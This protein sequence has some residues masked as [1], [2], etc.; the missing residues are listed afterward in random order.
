M[1]RRRFVKSI[2]LPLAACMA[3]TVVWV[4]SYR[5]MD[6][7][8]MATDT[9]AI[10]AVVVY[11]GAVHYVRGGTRAAS[12]P[13][14]Y[15]THEVPAGATWDHMYRFMSVRWR[16]AGFWS[17]ER[18]V[19][20]SGMTP[21]AAAPLVTAAPQPALAPWVFLASQEAWV[22]PFW[23]ALAVA[24]LPPV[25]LGWRT[26]WQAR[27]RRRAGLCPRCGYDLRATAARCPECGWEAAPAAQES[28]VI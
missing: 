8:S 6:E 14:S 7:W 26:W 23:P 18:M 3:I 16:F 28:K 12:R 21:Y 13:W 2:A 15:D 27:R 17:L 25:W 24:L 4:R 1:T 9:G 10:Q 11:Q 22:F 19:R 20:G 5:V